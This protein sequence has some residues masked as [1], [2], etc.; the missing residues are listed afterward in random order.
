MESKLFLLGVDFWG[1][2]EVKRVHFQEVLRE[3]GCGYES[4][5]ELFGTAAIG[6]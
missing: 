3:E 1:V 6:K 2:V 5:E 4:E